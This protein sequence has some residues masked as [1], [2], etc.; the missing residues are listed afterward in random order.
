MDVKI[1]APENGWLEDGLLGLPFGGKR[2]I[3]KGEPLVLGRVYGTKI[4]QN[5]HVFTSVCHVFGDMKP[6]CI[7]YRKKHKMTNT[8]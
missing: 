4:H 8:S 6:K 7:N 1:L 2:L 3:F 5:H